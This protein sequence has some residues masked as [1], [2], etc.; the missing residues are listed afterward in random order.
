MIESF[1]FASACRAKYII[2]NRAL[3]P[4]IVI[5]VND[6]TEIDKV[7]NDIILFCKKDSVYCLYELNQPPFEQSRILTNILENRITTFNKIFTENTYILITTFYGLIKKFPAPD[8]FQKHTLCLRH[9][10]TVSRDSLI[11][12][13]DIL[14]YISVEMVTDKG[15][16]AIRGDIFEV[17]P[18]G[19]ESPFRIE[20]IDDTIEDISFYNIFNHRSVQRV[21][22]ISIIPASEGL[23][24]TERFLEVIKTYNNLYEKASLYGKFAGH[25]WFA[26]LLN[27]MASIVDIINGNYGV[28]VFNDASSIKSL[29]ENI[30]EEK[31]LQKFPL[32]TNSI[33]LD[34]KAL[35]DFINNGQSN[36]HVDSQCSTELL[37]DY[38]LPAKVFIPDTINPYKN[39]TNFINLIK[40]LLK[41]KITIVVSIESK[42]FLE[43][44]IKF[45]NEYELTYKYIDSYFD[46][47]REKINIYKKVITGGFINKKA[48]L[49][50]F[51]EK[52]I[53]GFIKMGSK[54][55]RKASLQTTLLDLEIGSFVVHVD[56]GI[57]RFKGLM[58][59]TIGNI[60]ADFLV[61]EYE[62][63]EILYVPISS[64]NLIQ[65]Y[66]GSNAT[67]PR[68]SS[69]K[70]SNWA[71]IK[72][73]AYSSAKKV[74]VDLLK[75][76]GE[77]KKELGYSFKLDR[78]LLEKIEN[79]FEYDETEDQLAVLLDVYNDLT[80]KKS[81]DRLVCGDVG[82]GK[83]EIAIRAACVVA[84]NGKQV[85]L[86]TPTTVLTYQHYE[87]FKKRFKD[88]PVN[89]DF[90]CRFKSKKD[91]KDTKERL[92]KGEIDV[93]IGTHMLL[94]DDV[95]FHDLGLLIID[96]EQRF[97]VSQKEKIK[98]IKSNIDVLSITATPIPRT[99]QL[100]LSGLRDFSIIESPPVERQPVISKII[101]REEEII[102]VLLYE[103][104][105][106][107]Q[108]YYIHNNIKTIESTAYKLKENLPFARIVFAHAG[109]SSNKIEKIFK[110][111]YVG[112]ID[113]LVCTTIIENGIDVPHANTMIVDNAGDFGLSQLYQLKGRVGRSNKRAYFYVY[114]DSLEKLSPIARK[115]LNIMQQLSDLGSGFKIASYDL[116]LRGAGDILGAEQSGFITNMGYELYIEMIESAIK[117]I[118]GALPVG[119]KTEVISH[120]PNFIPA[121]YIE[122]Y[123]IRLD[124]Y[125]RIGELCSIDDIFA[126]ANE[127]ELE[128]GTIPDVVK[129]YFYI[130]LIKNISEKLSI[131]K[132]TFLPNTVVIKINP[133]NKLIYN[134]FNY[135]KNENVIIKQV[136]KSQIS[137]FSKRELLADAAVAISEIYNEYITKHTYKEEAI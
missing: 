104:K 79:S 2:D 110:D 87:T 16:Y 36:F 93:I 107:G 70:S 136:D 51:N 1:G 81:M 37:S 11:N 67:E 35:V 57:A 114:I 29:Y 39:I 101:N 102:D 61:L 69:L 98:S 68:L 128:F 134:L 74:A 85:A 88:L 63:N 40:Q 12:S 86:L 117:E 126:I 135:Y 95:I 109:M 20:F 65:K 23:Y 75:L 53:F 55:K 91:I 124:Y 33:F 97:G 45:F 3:F 116:Q 89:I 15:E 14:D 96:E 25:H 66:V 122:D 119:C 90:L 8:V 13:L 47:E 31:S 131:P 120:I 130:M 5:V 10:M 106:G 42:K 21:D 71:R 54:K 18:L 38:F 62:N 6:N 44:L 118:S 72:K 22:A 19:F 99:L 94:S 129:N 84:S 78:L 26:P 111:F 133:D 58:H 59:K 125:K 41:E 4:K 127:L 80:S 28:Y 132:I 82:F 105:R 108:S 92:A 115:R 7:Y 73:R 113:I 34:E 52:D 103:L 100:S 77:R 112:D 137:L 32:D 27:K 49:A 30:A 83:T 64:I 24:S 50:V 56:Y 123:R 121:S 17:F 46:A 76:Y 48:S 9:G 43:L 60:E